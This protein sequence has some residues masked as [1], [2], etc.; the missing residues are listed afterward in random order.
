M[1]HT[2]KYNLKI[3]GE[4]CGNFKTYQ[5][6]QE[7]LKEKKQTIFSIDNIRR[8]HKEFYKRENL[9]NKSTKRNNYL[10]YEIINIKKL[11]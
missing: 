2:E 7:Y 3:N 11:T 6:I 10:N 4:E 1:I 9:K 5:E 8:I